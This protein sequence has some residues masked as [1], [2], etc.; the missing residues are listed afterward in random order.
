MEKVYNELEE[1]L[2][3]VFGDFIQNESEISEEIRTIIIDKLGTELI[4][5]FS[6]VN[7]HDANYLIGSCYGGGYGFFEWI[8]EDSFVIQPVISNFK[9]QGLKL[10]NVYSAL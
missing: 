6:F 4:Y 7:I 1:N 3:I 8:D 5:G 9:E 10:L 2:Q